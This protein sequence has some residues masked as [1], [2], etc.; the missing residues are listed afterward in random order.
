VLTPI[1]RRSIVLS[2]AGLVLVLVACF[3]IDFFPG[4]RLVAWSGGL[5]SVWKVV[6]MGLELYGRALFTTVL[7][8]DLLV[9]LLRHSWNE[10]QAFRLSE[11]SGVLESKVRQLE[12]TGIGEL[13]RAPAPPTAPPAAG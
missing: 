7:F 3:T 10:A 2:A 11:L 9:A 13:R 1:H 4:M 12:E 5:L 8:S 6:E